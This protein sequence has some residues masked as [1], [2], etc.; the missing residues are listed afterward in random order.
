MVAGFSYERAGDGSLDTAPHS[1]R[2]TSAFGVGHIRR[3]GEQTSPR[4]RDR[5]SRTA[6]FQFV[7]APRPSHH[8]S[9]AVD[10]A[11]PAGAQDA[12]P[13]A[14]AARIP[15]AGVGMASLASC[16]GARSID[17]RPA[18]QRATKVRRR[19]AFNALPE[20]NAGCPGRST[21]SPQQ[22]APSISS[23]ALSTRPTPGAPGRIGPRGATVEA[24]AGRS[25][26]ST[27]RRS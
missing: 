1:D 24:A 12:G 23:A 14:P 18:L 19:Q 11:S 25:A 8:V 26:M 20:P 13:F 9:A 15:H 10:T 6:A 21:R 22:R 17:K 16:V 2:P 5:R 4:K 7:H 27:V 3:C